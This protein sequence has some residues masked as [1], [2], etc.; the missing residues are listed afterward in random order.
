MRSLRTFTVWL[1]EDSTFFRV[2]MFLRGEC[3]VGF[4]AWALWSSLPTE[5]WVW[6]IISALIAFGPTLMTIPLLASERILDK[7]VDLM[8]D[9]GDIPVLLFFICVMVAAL[10]LTVILRLLWAKRV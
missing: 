10:P 9:G 7:S 5:W 6:A 2:C 8:H 1:L 4:F 3:I